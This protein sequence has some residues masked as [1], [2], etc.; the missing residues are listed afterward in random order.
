MGE[1]TAPIGTL[2]KQ[3][4][5]AQVKCEEKEKAI[6]GANKEAATLRSLVQELKA[7]AAKLHG[8]IRVKDGVGAEDVRDATGTTG[9]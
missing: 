8:E 5:I 2:Q 4:S 3:V 1:H 9:A 7:D 6:E